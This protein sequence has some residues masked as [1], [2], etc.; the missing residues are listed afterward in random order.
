[1]EGTDAAMAMD[2]S[3]P[4]LRALGDAM[5]ID[6]DPGP[7]AVRRAGAPPLPLKSEAPVLEKSA[8]G[9]GLDRITSIAS[10]MM[11]LGRT[12]REREVCETRNREHARPA[13]SVFYKHDGYSARTKN[14]TMKEKQH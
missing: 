11:I 4:G 2:R 7:G 1:M 6:P 10:I 13:L 8:V 9:G 5:V 12:E 14:E 3:A